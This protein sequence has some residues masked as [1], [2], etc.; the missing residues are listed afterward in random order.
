MRVFNNRGSFRAIA[1][2]SED[3]RLNALV[4]TTCSDLDKAGS[5]S[6]TLVEAIN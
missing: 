4:T 5:I 2:V 6:D 3:L 1:Q